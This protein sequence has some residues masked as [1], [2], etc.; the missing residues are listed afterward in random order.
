MRA[1]TS[2]A[3]DFDASSAR[4]CLAASSPSVARRRSPSSA[5][6]SPPHD[7]A[8]PTGETGSTPRCASPSKA[9]D[10]EWGSAG[11]YDYASFYAASCS[12]LTAGDGEWASGS[13]DYALFG[14]DAAG[15][16]HGEYQ[17]DAENGS[18]SYT[19]KEWNYEAGDA[20]DFRP[21]SASYFASGDA[22]AW[23]YAYARPYEMGALSMSF[24]EQPAQ[25][26]VLLDVTLDISG[27]SCAAC[28]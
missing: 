7:D 15:P 17:L 9:G 18:Y 27:L 25:M 19:P 26:T 21:F 8:R 2:S 22:G 24:G 16:E 4:S 6:T 10:G 13:Y 11:S 5:A 23:S 28:E 12:Y 20:H 3:A 1:A 14:G